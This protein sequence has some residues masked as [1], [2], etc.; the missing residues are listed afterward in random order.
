MNSL[1]DL[2]E[3]EYLIDESIRK[4]EN[5]LE[6]LKK[7]EIGLG[8]ASSAELLDWNHALTELQN[9][10]TQMDQK[11]FDSLGRQSERHA[12]ID[13]RVNIRNHLIDEILNL[14]TDV[15]CK[16]SGVRSI[17]IHERGRFRNGLSALTG[18]RQFQNN[19]GKIVNN[20]F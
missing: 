16:A 10:A 13:I 14:N 12:E 19:Y 3:P 6:L 4:Y 17:I 7:V 11:V 2:Q 5:I 9:D 20:S 15:R 18:Y 8:T 1:I